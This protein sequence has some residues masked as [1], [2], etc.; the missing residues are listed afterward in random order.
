MSN[1]RF[2]ENVRNLV[3]R[4]VV[5]KK[6]IIGND[7]FTSLGGWCYTHPRRNAQTSSHKTDQTAAEGSRVGGAGHSASA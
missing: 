1:V 7:F 3:N 5:A 6:A 2:L 4:I